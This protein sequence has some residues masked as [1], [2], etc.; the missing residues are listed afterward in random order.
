MCLAS[1]DKEGNLIKQLTVAKARDLIADGTISGGMIPKVENL[2]RS[3]GTGA[4]KAL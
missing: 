3:I 2:Y 4:L 1:L